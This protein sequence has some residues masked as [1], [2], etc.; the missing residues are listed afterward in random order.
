MFFLLQET[1]TA[2]MPIKFLVLGG[3]VLEGGGSAQLALFLG[4]AAVRDSVASVIQTTMK[5]VVHLSH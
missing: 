4:F 2:D 3:G 5:L 1:K